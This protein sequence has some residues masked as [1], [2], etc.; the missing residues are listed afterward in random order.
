MSGAFPSLLSVFQ[1]WL[2]QGLRY[3]SYYEG[4]CLKTGTALSTTYY[5]CIMAL[6]I[7]YLVASFS[8][9]LPW[10][11]CLVEWGSSCVGTGETAVNDTSIGQDKHYSGNPKLW[12]TMVL[13]LPAGI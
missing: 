8:E 3:G 4:H 11:Y 1:S 10:S 12:R 5:T 13:E 2:H 7:R 9:V 6:T